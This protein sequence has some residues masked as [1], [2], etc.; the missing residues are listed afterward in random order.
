MLQLASVQPCPM[1]IF[2][3][4]RNDLYHAVHTAHLCFAFIRVAKLSGDGGVVCGDR[5]PR[6]AGALYG[7]LIAVHGIPNQ[8]IST[9]VRQVVYDKPL[10]DRSPCRLRQVRARR[11]RGE[12]S[13]VVR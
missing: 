13:V 10:V 12:M 7:H 2:R 4:T 5:D 9:C 3:Q 1:R 6:L 11:K 8:T